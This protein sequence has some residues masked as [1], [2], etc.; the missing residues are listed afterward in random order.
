MISIKQIWENILIEIQAKVTALAYDSWITDLKPIC[1][2]NDSIVLICESKAKKSVVENRYS[3]IICESCKKILPNLSGVLFILPEEKEHFEQINEEPIDNVNSEN[4]IIGEENNLFSP[5]C[6][7]G[8]FIIGKS[9]EFAAAASK[10]VAQ[11][12]GIKY[13]PLFIYGGVGLGK[14]HLLNAIGNHIKKTKP[15]LKCLYTSCE[16]FTNELI[17]ALRGSRYNDEMKEFRKK[18][19]SLDCLMIDDIQFISK[20]VSTQEELFHTFNDLYYQDKQIIICSDRPPQEIVPLEERLRTRFQG[21]VVADIV[22]P[23]LETRIAILQSEALTE[24][25]N[26]DDEILKLI[27]NKV[28]TNIREMKGVLTK[29]ICFAQLTDKNVNDMDLIN[30]ALKEYNEDKAEIVDI[31]KIVDCVCRYYPNVT[32]ADLIGKKKNKEIIEP[33]QMCVYLVTEFLSMPL[34]AIGQYFGGRDH[35]TIMYTRDKIAHLSQTEPKISAQI[36]D[37]K[38]MILGK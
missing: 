17:E 25:Q 20:T 12:P 38:A 29:I 36:K 37:I 4:I 35:T 5:K 8:N 33:R 15:K 2:H 9:N 18:Y 16:R 34:L 28:P 24:K 21:G 1:I 3:D 19:R 7:F 30:S 13:N 31:D 26:I 23:D 32:K 6:T 10:A 27:A 11:N 14:T 22:A